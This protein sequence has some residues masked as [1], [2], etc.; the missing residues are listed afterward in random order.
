MRAKQG[1]SVWKA[2]SFAVNAA[3]PGNSPTNSGGPAWLPG[4]SMSNLNP[5]FWGD[6]DR[7]VA[8]VASQGI[9]TSLAYAG[10]GRGMPTAE[11]EPAM[12]SLARY[13]VARYAAY[14]TVW[15]TCQEYCLG[16]DTAAWAA[17]AKLQYDL[18][19]YKRS[20]SLHN[21][22]SNPIAFH[23]QYWYGHVTLQQG[24]GSVTSVDHWLQQYNADP[25]RPIVEDEANYEMLF[26][27]KGG[28]P[29]WMTRQSAWSSQIGGSFGFTY[30]GQGVWWACWNLT[31]SNG[32]CGRVGDPAYRTWYQGL[33]MP[34][35]SVHL[36]HMASFFRSLPWWELAPNATAIDWGRE[37][38]SDSQRPYQKSTAN[39][40]VIVAYL[41][42]NSATPPP[43]PPPGP[44]APPVH[45]RN[46]P[47]PGAEGSA[48]VLNPSLAYTAQWFDPRTGAYSLCPAQPA[49]GAHSWKVPAVPDR[50]EDWVL[51]LEGKPRTLQQPDERA[52][53]S[54]TEMAADLSWVTSVKASGTP[55]RVASQ[56]GCEITVGTQT[57]H[58]TALGRF[59]APGDVNAHNLSIVT[60]AGAIVASTS[61]DLGGPAPVKPDALGFA[62]GAVQQANVK[63]VAHTVYYLLSDE[64]GCDAWHDDTGNTL[65]TTAAADDTASVYGTPPHTQKGAG[66]H[67]HCYGPLNFRYVVSV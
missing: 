27:V 1:Y 37:H 17:T 44:P 2:E 12:L 19:P 31:D 23:D 33:L 62:Y 5:K 9:V 40:S 51:L 58:V 52:L 53:G 35:G 3:E 8:Y 34:V 38:P 55:R 64:N 39:L 42:H 30:G 63:L 65:T 15:T 22:A 45:C 41:P 59:V 67:G 60:A 49:A 48:A 50:S 18:D 29:G 13:A 36:S 20:T 57:L 14:P 24:H 6:I 43:P 28:V 11:H 46:G 10:I 32:N 26:Y 7:R 47:T 61:F 54:L 21:C 25:P 66:G 4:P 56:V 16:G